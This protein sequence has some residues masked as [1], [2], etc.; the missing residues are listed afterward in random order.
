MWFLLLLVFF[1]APV[2][3]QENM[4]IQTLSQEIHA[5]LD[6]LRQQSRHLTEQLLIAEN[7]LRQSSLQA[8]TLKTELTDLNTCLDATNAK[9][10][11][12]SEKLTVYEERLRNQRAWILRGIAL[13]A[14]AV[15]IKLVVVILRFK[16]IRL[17]DWINILA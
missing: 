13:I 2:S 16:G 7:E 6:D 10:S 12:Y 14:L 3:A 5:Q 17:A 15:L 1:C 9:L 11:D 4:A 8:E